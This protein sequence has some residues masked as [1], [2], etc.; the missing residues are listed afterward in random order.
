MFRHYRASHLAITAGLALGLFLSG[1]TGS[2]LSVRHQHKQVKQHIE[3]LERL[4]RTATLAGDFKAMEGLLSDDFVGI[5]WNG[6]VSTKEMQID[7][8]R[9]R[10]FSMQKL[11]VS[12]EKV[13][14]IGNVAI[15]TATANVEGKIEGSDMK[16]A[17]RYT[18][19]YQKLLNGEW[20][21]TNF[22]A[23]RVNPGEPPQ[24]NHHGDR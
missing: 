10:S 12:D 1:A 6:Q 13:K 5:A 11:D 20:K 18:R 24:H 19:I 15:V 2:A 4:W 21:V 3:E 7:R 16:G 9:N 23:T 14:I 22:E 17:Y 8:L